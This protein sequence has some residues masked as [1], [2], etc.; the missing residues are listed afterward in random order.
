VEIGEHAVKEQRFRETADHA[1]VLP[2]VQCP[3]GY[4]RQGGAGRDRNLL[5]SCGP[6]P[7]KRYVGG[8]VGLGSSHA[9]VD[10]ALIGGG[11][12]SATLGMLLKIARP[13]ASINFI[14]RLDQ[15]GRES[16]D[17]WN[18]A[19]TGHAGLCELHYTPRRV[20][21]S[22]DIAKALLINEQFE[23]TLQFYA[24][25]VERGIVASPSSFINSSPHVGFARG[26]H[27]VDFLRRRHEA[28]AS[29]PQF[30]E[31]EYSGDPDQISEWLPLVMQGRRTDEPIAVTRNVTG[32]DVNFGSLTRLLVDELRQRGVDILTGHEVTGIDREGENRWTVSMMDRA[33]NEGRSVESRF[34][35]V[36]AG[37]TAIPL[38]QKSGIPEIKGYG[39]FPV[40]GQFLRCVNPELIARHNAKVYAKPASG[41]PPMTAP[42]LDTRVIDGQRGLM[43]GP[44]AGFS[45]KFL[46]QGS[47]LDFVRSIRPH[48]IGTMVTVAMY[49]TPLSMYLIREV[50]KSRSSKVA[51]LRQ[52]MPLAEDGDWELIQS[53]QRVQV[54]RP[55][56]GKRGIL[57]YGTEVI[58]S[59]DGSI[60]GLLGASPGASIAPSIML[61]VMERCFPN[62][63]G[64]WRPR[65]Q[66][67]MPSL[68]VVLANEPS[69]ARE[70]SMRS[71]RILGLSICPQGK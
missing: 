47:Y 58:A 24:W 40:G 62:E 68:G 71:N 35:F 41:A 6:Q 51:H 66:E 48:N 14:E 2:D 26:S 46:K 23:L 21:G 45:T 12:M 44:F 60:A 63:Y 53:G 5:I 38:L 39:G 7:L 67:A 15:A 64:R 30:A 69:L 65:L 11:I 33:S 70:L 10:I 18:N 27:D 52:F 49:E 3:K 9:Q 50:L 31:T 16:S 34:V 20:D 57:Q 25:L 17:P 28:L 32:S 56:P 4:I 61:N 55:I 22:I 43:F 36:G 37:G 13:D 19:G 54:M 1:T 42:H 29:Q 8:R 59:R